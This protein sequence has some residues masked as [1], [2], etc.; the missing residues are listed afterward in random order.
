[1]TRYL[2]DTNHVSAISKGEPAVLARMA[3]QP[4][5]EFAVALPSVGEL[6]F[7]VFNSAKIQ[8]NAEQLD[9]LLLDFAFM[10]FD[11]AA[12]REFGRIKSELRLKGRPIPDVDAQ[13]AAIARLH[14]I[15]LLTDDAHFA[16][17]D[18]LRRDNWVR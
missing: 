10:D 17:I 3:S 8:K 12:A 14:G 11:P 6:W 5:A 1:M 9:R 2:L 13:I 16:A 7:M 18:G 4:D 15:T